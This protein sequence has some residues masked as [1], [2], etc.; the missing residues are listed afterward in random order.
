MNILILGDIMGPSGRE[1]I[2]KKLPNLIKQK[3]ID[4]VIV[5]GENAAN[6]GV[7]ITKENTEEF[8]KAGTDVITTGNHVWDQKEALSYIDKE[9]RLLRPENLIQ[10]SPGKGFEIFKTKNNFKIG[11]LNLMG[12]I[13]MKKCDDVFQASKEFIKK[14]SEELIQSRPTA[15]NLQWA[16]HRMN[17]KLSMINSDDLFNVA[18]KEAKEICDE[19]V[20]FCENIGLNGLEI[21]KEIY[22]KKKIQ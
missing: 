3:K 1:A 5:N 2:T 12:N 7:G 8:F 22:N 6:P 11:V 9:N 17:N 16:V 15:I 19:D 10:P 4:F 21:I 13:F 20:K 18:L 14:S